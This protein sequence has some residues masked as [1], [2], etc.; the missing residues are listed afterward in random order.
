MA[1]ERGHVLDL[2]NDTA[3]NVAGL[4]QAQTGSTR[5]YGLGLDRFPLD[6]EMAA[7]NVR[8]EVKLTRL[9]T[10][11]MARV[12][13]EGVVALECARCLRVYDQGFATEFAEEYRQTVDVRTGVGLP[14]EPE[15][16]VDEETSTIDENHELD[17]AE[18]L[19]QEILVALPMRPDCGEACPGPDVVE[20]GEAGPDDDRFAALARLLGEDGT[21]R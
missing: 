15:A 4:L 5:S 17:L 16:E 6:G 19:R 18:V 8:G 3:I 2:R 13:A 21:G 12:S 7:E 1:T 11:V 9:R 10:G 14:P 20:S